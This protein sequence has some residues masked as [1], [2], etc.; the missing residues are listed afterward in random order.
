MDIYNLS[1]VDSTIDGVIGP[2]SVT[3]STSSA[4]TGLSS[5]T[6]RLKSTRAEI[7]S[8]GLVALAGG[9]LLEHTNILAMQVIRARLIDQL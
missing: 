1:K 9:Q 4:F 7:K 8:P 6:A 2:R 3:A 5:R